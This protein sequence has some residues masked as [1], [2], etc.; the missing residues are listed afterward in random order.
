MQ[1]TALAMISATMLLP[2]A[3]CAANPPAAASTTS[4]TLP[5]SSTAPAST[6]SS[7]SALSTNAHGNL[8]KALGQDAGFTDQNGK[9]VVRFAVDSVTV[10]PKCDRYSGGHPAENGHLV[11]L[12][13]RVSTTTDSSSIGTVLFSADDFSY[14]GPNGITTTG[15]ASG[16]AASCL[17]DSEQMTQ[18]P[19]GPG[20]QYVGNVVLDIPGTS[21]SIVYAPPGLEGDAHG[22]EW[23]F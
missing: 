7:S 21:G 18:S 16:A 6:P 23:T 10:D 9:V 17:K 1:R 4:V 11:A 2:L 20:Q 22:W 19:V 14:I 12:K 3:A 8:P 5:P 13:M 15:L